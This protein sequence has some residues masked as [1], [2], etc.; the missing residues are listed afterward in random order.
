MSYKLPH[1]NPWSLMR[2]ACK[3]VIWRI[4]RWNDAS[5]DRKFGIDTCGINDD[6]SALGVNDEDRIHAH[7]YEPIQLPVFNRIIKQ[8]PVNDRDYCFVDY[9]S[10]KARAMIMA[11]E[12]GFKRIIGVEFAPLLHAAAQRNIATYLDKRPAQAQFE[13]FCQDATTFNLPDC[14]AVLFFYNPFDDTV[15]AKVLATIEQNWHSHPRDLI[16]AYRNP[17]YANVFDT[18][19][20]LEPLSTDTSFRLYRTR[21]QVRA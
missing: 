10:G 19:S 18:A 9:G 3:P 14:N 4:E 15:L 17:V 11:A 8:L 13:N 5:L 2:R 7:G 16:I 20:F 21:K 6:L 1:F 12:A